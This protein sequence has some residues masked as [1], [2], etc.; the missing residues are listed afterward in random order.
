MPQC[1]LGETRR[2]IEVLAELEA[3]TIMDMFDGGDVVGKPPTMS[4]LDISLRGD[5]VAS[6]V[7]MEE[8]K[9]GDVIVVDTL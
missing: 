8:A 9:V 5:V 4:E 3:V 7:S 6:P 1:P 2:A